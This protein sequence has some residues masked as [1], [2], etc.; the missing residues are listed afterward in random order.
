MTGTVG[1]AV[2]TWTLLANTWRFAGLAAITLVLG[3][4]APG[5]GEAVP[6]AAA[7]SPQT[8]EPAYVLLRIPPGE[9]TPAG[10]LERVRAWQRSGAV[11]RAVWLSAVPSDKPA[12]TALVTLEFS[13]ERSFARWHE[14]ESEKLAPASARRADLLTRGETVPRDSRKAVFKANYYQPKVP[15]EQ[16][17]Q[18]AEGYIERFMEVQ[19]QA[20]LLTSY[21][22]FLERGADGQAL[23]ILEHLDQATFDSV[24]PV[25][26]KLRAALI[27]RD[28]GY[29]RYEET[30]ASYRV[31]VSGTTAGYVPLD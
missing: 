7:H 20:N 28:A 18:F 12:F 26:E 3:A 6:V 17:R 30:A 27:E 11:D 2:N 21:S 8:E 16:F 24:T 9:E 22:M 4:C 25:K 5:G 1:L 31:A 29:A 13:S 19:R 14:V 15:P 10:L 23:L